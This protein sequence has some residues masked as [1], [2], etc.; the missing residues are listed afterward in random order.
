[1]TRTSSGWLG[2]GLAS[3]VLSAACGT[4][5]PSTGKPTVSFVT[6]HDQQALTAADGVVSTAG[7]LSIAVI[8]KATS[9]SA[10]SA[11][12]LTVD[13]TATGPSALADSSGNLKF[14]GVPLAGSASGISH[15]LA[16]SIADSGGAGAATA[17]I[18]VT[19]TLA[20]SQGACPISILPADQS[21]FNETGVAVA[22]HVSVRDE[23]LA[24]A[25][26]QAKITVAVGAPCA[27][28]SPVVLTVGNVP[29]AA[30][31]LQGG[32]ATFDQ[33]TLP[34]TSFA[35][36]HNPAQ[37]LAV[38]ASA[39][40]GSTASTATVHYYVDSQIP[41]AAITAPM[42]GAALGNGQDIDPNTPGLQVLVTGTTTVF[43]NQ[44]AAGIPVGFQIVDG[45]GAPYAAPK[46]GLTLA[47]DGSFSVEITL[48][49][50]TADVLQFVAT[51][52]TGNTAKSATVTVAVAATP[53]IQFV[54][55]T[56]GEVLNL[57]YDESQTT[58]GLQV[59]IRVSTTATN[60]SPVI[61]CSTVSP[62]SGAATCP[63][64]TGFQVAQTTAAG[65]GTIAD[66]VTL[67]DDGTAASQTLT[68]QVSDGGQLATA[69]VA[70]SVHSLKPV[71]ESVK[72]NQAFIDSSGR[73][74]LNASNLDGG[75]AQTTITVTVD[76]S[77]VYQGDGGV[78]QAVR[79]SNTKN[80]A[81][82]FSAPLTFG[83]G[84]PTADVPV[85]LA[86]GA[87]AFA[88][89]VVDIFGNV[90]DPAQT[91]PIAPTVTVYVKTTLPACAISAPTQ[92][93]YFN[94]QNNGGV[95][96][97]GSVQVPVALLPTAVA[98]VDLTGAPIPGQATITVSPTGSG[99]APV[100]S[101]GLLI[102][103]LSAQ[104]ADSYT[105]T[106]SDP[107]N[108]PAQTCSGSFSLTVA[109]VGPT[110]TVTPEPDPT[111]PAMD[112]GEQIYSTRTV[113]L[114]IA[115]TGTT[116][117]PL[118]V[119]ISNPPA[120][121][122]PQQFASAGGTTA[123]SYTHAPSGQ[124]TVTATVVDS[125]GNTGS[126]SA[127]LFV[128]APGC[129]L[130]LTSP[131]VTPVAGG[132]QA[133]TFNQNSGTVVGS[134]LT[135]NVTLHTSLACAGNSVTLQL[136]PNGQSAQTLHATADSSGNVT[137]QLLSLSDGSSGTLT[138]S[139]V[140]GD[141]LPT[142][143]YI[144]KLSNPAI[145][146]TAPSTTAVQIVA[147]ADNVFLNLADGGSVSA[148]LNADG[149]TV[150]ASP[151][152]STTAAYG[153]FTVAG[154]TGLGPI[155]GNGNVGSATLTQNFSGAP[156]SPIVLPIANG[157]TSVTF[158]NITLPA[159]SYPAGGLVTI[160]ISDNAGNLATH[161]WQ[162]LTDVIAPAAPV[163]TATMVDQ[164]KAAVQLAWTVPPQ[165]TASPTQNHELR[166]LVSSV[167]SSVVTSPS[168]PQYISWTLDPTI[169]GAGGPAGQALTH[170]LT[171]LAT[172]NQYTFE[173]RA[174]DAVGNRSPLAATTTVSSLA[175]GVANSWQTLTLQGP[176]ASANSDFGDVLATGNFNNDAYKDLVISAPYDY[177]SGVPGAVYVLYGA[178][179]YTGVS[180][181]WP[182]LS[183]VTI[184]LGG[185][186]SDHFG[187]SMAVGD[188]N[189]D[190]FDDLAVG[191]P[192][193]NNKR[194]QVTLFFG[195]AAG[196]ATS[197][198]VTLLGDQSQPALFGT[199]VTAIGHVNRTASTDLIVGAPGQGPTG[200]GAV[201]LFV[202]QASWPATPAPAAIITGNP[203]DQL[204]GRNA[205]APLG[206]VNSDGS[207][208]FV[209]TA[210]GGGVDGGPG[211]VYGISGLIAS[212]Q[213]G[214][215]LSVNTTPLFPPMA[216]PPGGVC[217]TIFGYPSTVYGCVGSNVLGGVNFTGGAL[218]NLLVNSDRNSDI[219][220]FDVTAAGIQAPPIFRD[221]HGTALGFGMTATDLN[222]D[223]LPDLIAGVNDPTTYSVYF[224]L[225]TGT[226]LQTPPSAILVGLANSYFG[227][228]VAARDIRGV[229]VVDFAVGN[230]YPTSF[231]NVYY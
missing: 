109:T 17:S 80:N 36:L 174:V 55:P 13:G 124:D 133:I 49:N 175:Q 58:P 23:N 45:N 210:P 9:V 46:G 1:M 65:A 194:G 79:L 10:G 94:V 88:V 77:D 73:A 108:N 213:G 38:T 191:A 204:G 170:T 107:A 100:G 66:S 6:P 31:N 226:G 19:V 159:N 53:T 208:D 151:V 42:T 41:T 153:Q 147:N 43:A 68:V 67:G 126:G 172:L 221:T 196:L 192:F 187:Y 119:T 186:T 189:G 169:S 84:N 230:P 171:G 197:P 22:G 101:G 64:G 87:Y 202:G 34:D 138:A 137:F 117:E 91:Q 167:G 193:S 2:L 173:L 231:V 52:A 115:T 139:V 5:K 85:T 125:A 4:T 227:Y 24:V 132:G 140:G 149:G 166:Y 228:S 209:V 103:T 8:A 176:A 39:G 99:T 113:P 188:F 86:D 148:A 218:P 181:S 83:G 75:E 141:S 97:S 59:A 104:G 7:T 214:A 3:A 223:G 144:T 129:D 168:Q 185:G 25:G 82:S 57:N 78:G 203:G 112:G 121:G 35:A 220:M 201:Y 29:L 157:T 130:T 114:S 96:N 110:V 207:P 211:T 178:K 98:G 116:T 190:G 134:F 154:L 48:P 61:V 158:S 183:L 219:W 44:I 146:S 40:A 161:N 143:G 47:T 128:A 145:G 180:T 179:D 127:P 21:L 69:S 136:T 118:I 71:I 142:I 165:G 76:A 92:N 14:T 70:V 62:S 164:R 198:S 155:D 122:G 216:G 81:Q 11:A 33:A 123:V 72:V 63:F 131:Q 225:N 150:V 160:T 12:A 28:G 15:H 182:S 106:V 51:T 95:V 90:S 20:T 93:G 162:V 217:N 215:A 89:S 120:S 163:A 199:S 206:D 60:G 229:G 26:M 205:G 177:A 37:A 30:V 135:A 105:A 27:D 224:Y 184:T 54:S 111:S 200:S 195:S 152:A 212:T 18:T 74:W 156:A 16:I 222:G 56:P 102:P 50:G 32:S